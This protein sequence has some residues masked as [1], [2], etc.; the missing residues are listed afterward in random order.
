MTLRQAARR[1]WHG[2]EET[3]R[4]RVR[5]LREAGYLRMSS[6]IRW[7]G[8]CVW[9][10]ARG[11]RASSTELRPPEW[12]GERL[13]HRLAMTDAAFTFELG[14]ARVL[15][16]R[17]VRRAEAT[18]SGR[19]EQVAAALT[20]QPGS[21]FDGRGRERFLCAPVG[22]GGRVHYP[23]LVVAAPLGLVA[24]E[25]EITAKSPAEIRQVLR[26]Y[27]DSRAVFPQVVYF[28]TEP[29][30][31]LLHGHA[32]PRTGAWSDGVAQQVGLLPPGPPQYRPD[33]P[34]LV[35]HFQPKDP[36]VAYQLD[37]RQVPDTWRVD[38]S[39]WK[40][41]RERWAMEAAG[42]GFLTWWQQQA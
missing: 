29:V 16:E 15:S 13:L 23:D 39:R 35:R 36:G 12:P 34:F 8:A 19:A 10:T 7:A 28:A 42:V 6:D 40:Q 9:T 25:V 38:F 31:A 5:W 18:T 22:A 1:Y 14:G 30:M 26:S 27:R 24:V 20:R 11:A 4:Q 2:V 32:H 17:E 21:T 37:L 33:S 3:A 41:L